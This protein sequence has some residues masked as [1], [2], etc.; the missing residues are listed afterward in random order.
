M[1]TETVKCQLWLHRHYL[2]RRR[3]RLRMVHRVRSEY[4]RYLNMRSLMSPLHQRR[5]LFE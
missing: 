5:N 4:Q 2:V 1:S 3:L